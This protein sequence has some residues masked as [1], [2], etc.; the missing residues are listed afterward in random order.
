MV[1]ELST[2]PVLQEIQLKELLARSMYYLATLTS[3]IDMR[4]EFEMREMT[5]TLHCKKELKSDYIPPPTRYGR[6]Y[7]GSNAS[8][9]S[10]T[11]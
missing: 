6:Y 11:D 2:N 9:S 5:V 1:F 10:S 3:P 4:H 8:D 7:L